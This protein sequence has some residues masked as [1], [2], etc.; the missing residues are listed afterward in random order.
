MFHSQGSAPH[1]SDCFTQH[2]TPRTTEAIGKGLILETKIRV[3][4]TLSSTVPQ[5]PPPL[6]VFSCLTPAGSVISFEIP[7]DGYTNLPSGT[8]TSSIRGFSIIGDKTSHQYRLQHSL[9]NSIRIHQSFAYL[10]LLA[11][12]GEFVP[13]AEDTPPA[14]GSPVAVERL[15]LEEIQLN[16]S[17][18][19][20]AVDSPPSPPVELSGDVFTVHSGLPSP[21]SLFPLRILMFIALQFC[22][23]SLSH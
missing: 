6:I 17:S 18:S 10:P 11:P 2:L 9:W 4:L 5:P 13:D 12:P 1:S 21:L 3:I 16:T 20:A 14:A 23:R 22:Q 8:D 19:T 7:L 15:D